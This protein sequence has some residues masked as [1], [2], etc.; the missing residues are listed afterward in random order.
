MLERVCTEATLLV[1]D[2]RCFWTGNGKRQTAV[3]DWQDQIK[4][5]F[6]LAGISSGMGNAVSHRFRDTFGCG[7]TFNWRADRTVVRSIGASE[8]S[9]YREALQ[10]L[11]ALAPRAARS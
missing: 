8:C 7:I 5:V 1:T 2:T 9:R 10:P 6:D 11:G 3:C 4:K